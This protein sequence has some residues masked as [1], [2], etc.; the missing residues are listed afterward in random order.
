[1]IYYTD[2]HFVCVD[3]VTQNDADIFCNALGY[4]SGSEK[5]DQEPDMNK[6]NQEAQSKNYKLIKKFPKFIV[7][8]GVYDKAIEV[9]DKCIPAI[10]QCKGSPG[11]ISLAATPKSLGR[12]TGPPVKKID[13]N[14]S[15]NDITDF[16]RGDPGSVFTFI[17]P[18]GCNQGGN[19]F[20]TGLYAFRSSICK[21]AIHV[22]QLSSSQEGIVSVAIGYPQKQLTG[23]QNAENVRSEKWPQSN[24]DSEPVFTFAIIPTN[25]CYLVDN[26]PE[27]S[28]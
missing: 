14:T 3:G 26:V 10:I 5:I 4:K 7:A 11:D 2:R 22:N 18:V 16:I 12:L 15:M 17:C 27:I 28:Y 25:T 9:T 8:S 24:D 21:A 23:S 13:C 6:F 19:M 20:G 1:M